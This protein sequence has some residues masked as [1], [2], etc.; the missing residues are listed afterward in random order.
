MKSNKKKCEESLAT[1]HDEI[2]KCFQELTSFKSVN[3]HS[4]RMTKTNEIF[5]TDWVCDKFYYADIKTALDN[6]K[7][8]EKYLDII[9]EHKNDGQQ[10]RLTGHKAY[11]VIEQLVKCRFLNNM[12]STATEKIIAE[13]L[14]LTYQAELECERFYNYDIIIDN[15][16]ID[17]KNIK[18]RN[19]VYFNYDYDKVIHYDS[20]E[21]KR[22]ANHLI[23]SQQN[24]NGDTSKMCKN[25]LFCLFID[26]NDDMQKITLSEMNFNKIAVKFKEIALS[27]ILDDY[28]FKTTVNEEDF[29]VTIV[30]FSTDESDVL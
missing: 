27:R 21:L 20:T 28:S 16:K 14:G 26:S 23:T 12:L 25:L 17:V 2:L 7:A 5:S 15:S 3:S 13:C 8:K 29:S 6:I 22:I 18:L 4:I 11:L 1:M 10:K 24:K 9:V 19:S 30:V